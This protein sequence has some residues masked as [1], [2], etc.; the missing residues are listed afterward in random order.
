MHK[1]INHVLQCI[2]INFFYFSNIELCLLLEKSSFLEYRWII[3][4]SIIYKYMLSF[5]LL[6][7]FLLKLR[8][9]I[10]KN[11][12]DYRKFSNKTLNSQWQAWANCFPD[13]LTLT[14]LNETQERLDNVLKMSFE[15]KVYDKVTRSVFYFICTLYQSFSVK[16][17]KLFVKL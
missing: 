14:C 9:L 5:L 13:S 15:T 17:A 8:I 3:F 4:S 7:E 1:I 10:R 2:H 11:D 12:R 6:L 16:S